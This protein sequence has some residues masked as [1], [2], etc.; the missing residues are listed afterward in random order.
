MTCTSSYKI[1]VTKAFLGYTDGCADKKRI[2]TCEENVLTWLSSKC[3][4]F[5]FCSV[6]WQALRC[7]KLICNDE[8]HDVNYLYLKYECPS[9]HTK[10]DCFTDNLLQMF[11]ITNDY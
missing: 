4:G 3:N 10:Y 1:T 11:F 6:K 5:S 8:G 7:N 2:V 9:K